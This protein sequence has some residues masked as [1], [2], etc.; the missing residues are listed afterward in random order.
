MTNLGQRRAILCCDVSADGFLVA[1]GTDFQGEDALILYWCVL[2]NMILSNSKAITVSNR[3]P[4][5]PAAPLRAHSE[6]HSDDITSLHFSSLP[7]SKDI[8]SASSDGLLSI[9]N[10]MEDD[11]DDATTHVSNWGTSISQAGWIHSPSSGKSKI[12]A[13]SDMETFS[14]WSD[15]VC[16]GADQIDICP[17]PLAI[18]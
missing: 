15:E 8:L 11:G 12:W 7:S 4:R 6:T 10:A 1:G 17:L 18:A 16:K 14:S 2:Y 3:D 13:A 5:Q 9:S